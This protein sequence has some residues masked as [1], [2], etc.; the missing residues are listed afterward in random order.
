MLLFT[1]CSKFYD[2]Q[3]SFC[4]LKL[5][6]SEFMRQILRV[7]YLFSELRVENLSLNLEVINCF[8]RVAVSLTS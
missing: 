6:I 2:L 5:D 8:L 4:E 1:S 3:V 7:E